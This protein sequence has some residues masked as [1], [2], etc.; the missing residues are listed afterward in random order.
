VGWFSSDKQW[1][2]QAKIPARNARNKRIAR[3]KALIDARRANRRHMIEHPVS[4]AFR[5]MWR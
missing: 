1:S 5:A 4:H 2:N 3:R